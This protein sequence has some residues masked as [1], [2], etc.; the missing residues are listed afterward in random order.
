[1]T[2]YADLS[3]LAAW[4]LRLDG[5]AV[6]LAPPELRRA[7]AGG[8]RRVIALHTGAPPVPAKAKPLRAEEASERPTGPV[9]PERFGVL[10]ALLACLLA[11]CGENSSAVIPARELVERFPQ[12]PEGGARGA[13]VAA[14]PRQLRRRLLRRLRRAAR[15]RGAR[16]QGAVR[17]HVP[18]APA[19]D[20]AR[21]ARDPA[22]ARVRRPDDRRRGPPAAR[23]GAQEARGDVRRVRPPADGRDP[24]GQ[25]RGDADPDAE[26]RDQERQPGRA[27][28]LEGRRGPGGD[29][30]RRAVRPRAGAPVLVRAH[31][32]PHPRRPAQLPARPDAGRTPDRRDVRAAGGL[33]DRSPARCASGADR[34]LACHRPLGG[35]ARRRGAHRR[36]GADGAEG[37]Q[38]RVAGQRDPALPRRGGR[39][40][41][42]RPA[43]ARRGAGAGVAQLAGIARPPWHACAS[44]E[45][46]W[47]HPAKPA[48]RAQPELSR[49][50]IDP[51]RT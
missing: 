11:A 7:V 49:G 21:G 17:R 26:R 27:R 1:M 28:V 43:E 35:R 25:G 48:P 46:G 10:Q 40:R 50:E 14:Q 36:H 15:R 32:G 4:I 13:P 18:V 31:V 39:R 38:P 37:R 51:R 9:N 29:A 3:H 24:T 34:L 22:R 41:A 42:G 33:R 19:P 8:L 2:P 20:A 23:P 44:L 12:I 45:R 30:S 6:P 16:R 47:L 5:R